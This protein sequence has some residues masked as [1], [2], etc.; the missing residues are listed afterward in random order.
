MN[1][2]ITHEQRTHFVQAGNPWVACMD[3]LR[4]EAE[5][6]DVRQAPFEVTTMPTGNTETIPMSTVLHLQTLAVNHDAETTYDTKVAP[7]MDLTHW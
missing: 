7:R 2:E 3:V 4:I 5:E 6:N 1:Y